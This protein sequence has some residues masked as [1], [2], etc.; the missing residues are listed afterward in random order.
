MLGLGFPWIKLMSKNV[1]L[2]RLLYI[3][4]D[5]RKSPWPRRGRRSCVPAHTHSQSGKPSLSLL[6]RNHNDTSSCIILSGTSCSLSWSVIPIYLL[7]GVPLGCLIIL[8][9]FCV[10]GSNL[11]FI[12]FHFPI[13]T[14]VF[15]WHGKLHIFLLQNYG[16][17]QDEKNSILEKGEAQKHIFINWQYENRA[18]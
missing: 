14:S 17:N 2:I 10:R 15:I 7:T 16:P 13:V 12:A 1:N 6:P 11:K 9:V 5:Q 4:N 8:P 3:A 18:W